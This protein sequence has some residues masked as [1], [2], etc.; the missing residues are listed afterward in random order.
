MLLEIEAPIQRELMIRKLLS[1]YGVTKQS[2]TM[3]AIEKT[4][5]S[6]GVKNIKYKGNVFCW[7][8]DQDPGVYSY[9]RVNPDRSADELPLHEIRNAICLILKQ[10]GIMNREELITET[11]YLFGYKRSGSNLKAAINNGLM[12]AKSNG[13]IVFEGQSVLLNAD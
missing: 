9:V 1:S 4:L 3:D 7:K 13:D 10:K 12:F 2:L 6:V 11:I 8:R 5:K